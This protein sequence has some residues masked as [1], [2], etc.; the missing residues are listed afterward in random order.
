MWELLWSYL[1][2]GNYWYFLQPDYIISLI[3]PY[4]QF[5]YV[6]LV[7]MHLSAPSSE[8]YGGRYGLMKLQY[9][10]GRCWTGMLGIRARLG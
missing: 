1:G 6:I 9:I 2:S 8:D 3:Q 10:R 5:I 7:P 4:L